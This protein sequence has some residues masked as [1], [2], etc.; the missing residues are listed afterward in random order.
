VAGGFVDAMKSTPVA[1]AMVVVIFALIG[2]VYY[3]AS[4]FSAQR[5]SN[6]KLFLEV[7]KLMSQCIVPPK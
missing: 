5:E 7:Q 6:G 1:L 3:Q 4:M 2:L